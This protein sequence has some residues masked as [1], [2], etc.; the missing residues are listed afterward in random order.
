MYMCSSCQIPEVV[1][2]IAIWL[3][4]FNS[5]VNPFLYAIGMREIRASLLTL[6]RLLC[7]GVRCW[8]TRDE[9]Q[10]GLE[11]RTASMGNESSAFT[12]GRG[13]FPQESLLRSLKRECQLLP[14]V[15]QEHDSIGARGSSTSDLAT[16]SNQDTHELPVAL[17]NSSTTNVVTTCTTSSSSSD[18]QEDSQKPYTCT[19]HNRN[20]PSF[21]ISSQ[22]PLLRHEPEEAEE[23]DFSDCSTLNNPPACQYKDV[24]P[25]HLIN[26]VTSEHLISTFHSDGE[27]SQ[28]VDDIGDSSSLTDT[29]VNALCYTVTVV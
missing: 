2:F 21:I 29:G 14:R 26:G 11:G 10:A 25:D 24:L 9:A 18:H 16:A 12:T 22:S 13:A 1:I 28:V 15:P 27:D 6:L 23:E 20:L 7:P 8:Q 17:Q 5:A 3:T 4:H 19:S